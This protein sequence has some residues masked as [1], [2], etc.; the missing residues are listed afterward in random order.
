L[1]PTDSDSAIKELTR[2]LEL[3]PSSV[4]ARYNLALAYGSNGNY[5]PDKELEELKKVLAATPDFPR[6]HVAL[7]RVL[8]TQ[9]NLPE[10]I[11]HLQRA[12]QLDP[13]LGEAHY[14][15]GLALSRAGRKSE[16][17]PELQKG[18]ELVEERER[19]QNLAL[20]LSEGRAALERGDL[21]DAKAK[22]RHALHEEPDSGAA[23]RLLGLALAKQGDTKGGVAALGK[24]LEI[25]PEDSVA[26]SNLAKLKPPEASGDDPNAINAT[27]TYIRQ[28]QFKE[29]ESLLIT[30]LRSRPNSAWGWYALGY[31]QFAQRLIGDSIRSLA[32]SLQFDINN[33]EAHKILGRD[34]LIVG[35]FDAARIEFEQG[36]RLRPDSAELHY[37]FGKLYSINDEWASARR[38]LA[39]AVR[40]DPSYVEGWDALGFA[41][42]ALGNGT[43]AVAAYEKAI[44]LNDACKGRFSAAHVDLS[45]FY[46]RTGKPDKAL[47]YARSALNLNPQDDRAWFQMGRAHEHRGELDAAVSSVKHA[48]ELNSHAA[49]YYYVLATLYRR[50]D[51]KPEFRQALARFSELDKQSNDLERKRRDASADSVHP[52]PALERIAS[53]IR[54]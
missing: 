4:K 27:E 42:E 33:A 21:D 24:A 46:N 52:D 26:S 31:S 44:S 45:A 39:E 15:L 41:E 49:P 37:N 2:A 10:A 20:D 53:E 29:A 35:R 9:R 6:A 34:L 30:Y 51:K 28:K 19:T 54:E 18:R 36:I 8:L 7:G 5:G 14:Q 50:Q 3:D 43:Q 23:N 13:S 22:F 48:T 38:E 47:A 40:L 11:E 17:A 32:K 12:I 25:D 16:A 1:A